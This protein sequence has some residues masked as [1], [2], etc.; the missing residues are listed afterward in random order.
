VGCAA[1]SRLVNGLLAG[2]LDRRRYHEEMAAL[3]A[4]TASPPVQL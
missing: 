2:T 3:A 1:E 4:G